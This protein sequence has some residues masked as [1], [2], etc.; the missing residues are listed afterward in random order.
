MNPSKVQRA[1]VVRLEDLP[2][3]GPASA[4]D[5]RLLGITKP[6]QL[7]GRDPMKLYDT[8]CRKT[9]TRHDPCVIDL[10][11]SVVHFMD[12]GEPLP[13]WHFTAERKRVLAGR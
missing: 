7:A 11:M 12:G 6:A 10:F 4:G 1:A 2:N 5:L 9:G 3:V 8:L 13:W